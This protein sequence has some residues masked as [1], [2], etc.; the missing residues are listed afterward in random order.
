MPGVSKVKRVVAFVVIV[1]MRMSVMTEAV[2]V[3]VVVV[4]VAAAV[5]I[6]RRP[7]LSVRLG[8]LLLLSKNEGAGGIDGK[9]R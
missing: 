2:T 4:V 9:Q 1:M 5:P 6:W 8:L 7:L 3:V